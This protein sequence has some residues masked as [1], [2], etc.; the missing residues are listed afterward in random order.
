MIT[1]V[2][3]PIIPIEPSRDLAQ[4]IDDLKAWIDKLEKP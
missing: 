2:M 1:D 4:E 3:P